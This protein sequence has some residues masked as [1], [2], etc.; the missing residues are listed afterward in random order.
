[1]GF[2]YQEPTVQ[3]KRALQQSIEPKAVQARKLK[4]NSPKPLTVDKCCQTR[5]TLKF[6]KKST[7]ME[8]QTPP[9]PMKNKMNRGT[10]SDLP[11]SKKHFE[12]QEVD[13]TVS[14]DEQQLVS[15]QD[16]RKNLD[17][18]EEQ[19]SI[20]ESER[21]AAQ[22]DSLNSLNEY[23]SLKEVKLLIRNKKKKIGLLNKYQKQLKNQR[24]QEQRN[25]YMDNWGMS[26]KKQ[27]LKY[28]TQA[29]KKKKK[30]NLIQSNSKL[31]MINKDYQIRQSMQELKR[32]PVLSPKRLGHRLTS[33]SRVSAQ[34]QSNLYIT[35]TSG[36]LSQ[37]NSG[38]RSKVVP[39]R[40]SSVL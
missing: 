19:T 10:A 1:M 29:P 24:E 4:D 32:N 8:S 6:L 11:F 15:Y 14:D 3:V 34:Y 18:V 12:I 30:L 13:E 33:A 35:N 7:N 25:V 38:T 28:V 16:S 22:I 37:A 5:L 39:G 20:D 23:N 9:L 2:A 21:I 31:K 26:N 27:G 17:I 36:M 40:Y